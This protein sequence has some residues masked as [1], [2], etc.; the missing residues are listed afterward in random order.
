MNQR[1]NTE[2]EADSPYAQWT[3][4]QP[5]T[6]AI[7]P[8]PWI[9]IEIVHRA[10]EV[11]EQTHDENVLFT[12]SLTVDKRELGP[13]GS[14]FIP[15]TAKS[16]IAKFIEWANQLAQAHNRPHEMIPEDPEGAVTV[17]RFRRTIAWYIY[18]QPGGRIALGVQYG[19]V[20]TAM[21]E[22][23]AGR[24]R[25]DMLEVLDFERGLAMADTLATAA[26]RIEDREGISGPAASRYVAAASEFQN[27]FGG[28]YMSKKTVAALRDNPKLQVFDSP[29][30]F[31]TCNYDAFKALCDPARGTG[32]DPQRTPD[33]SRCNPACANISRTDGQIDAARREVTSIDIEIASGLN[34]APIDARL[35]QRKTKL[36]EVIERHDAERIVPGHS[37]DPQ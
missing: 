25:V 27:K 24:S 15:Q 4:L 22:S 11:L 34:P 32:A 29:G 8:D 14:V 1:T 23:Y 30:A 2:P 26:E 21:G 37:E 16:H 36:E 9:V 12:R 3:R 13:R 35:Q 6:R 28:T 17:Q 5:I 33:R 19:H 20:A 18:R 31:M 7:R 10:I